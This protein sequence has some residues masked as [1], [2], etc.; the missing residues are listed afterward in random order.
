MDVAGE[1]RQYHEMD[2]IPRRNHGKEGE[3]PKFSEDVEDS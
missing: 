3:G 2:D 1:R